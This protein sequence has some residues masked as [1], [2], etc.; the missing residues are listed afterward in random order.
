MDAINANDFVTKSGPEAAVDFGHNNDL[1]IAVSEVDDRFLY[2]Q[3]S[4]MVIDGQG[5]ISNP[6][7][8]RC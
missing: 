2:D 8:P 5:C 1:T 4:D 6:T 3:S 7:G